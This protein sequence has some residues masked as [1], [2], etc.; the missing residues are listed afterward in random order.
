[1]PI[2][3]DFEAS[4]LSKTSYPIE[5]GWVDATGEGESLLIRPPV[6]W[7]DW[8]DS[9]EAIHG[10]TRA[11]LLEQGIEVGEVCRRLIALWEQG[12]VY[13]SA[14]SW[15]GAWLSRLLRAGGHPRH[16]LRLI[17]SDEAFGEAARQAGIPESAI[18]GRIAAARD[19]AAE[20][21]VAHRAQADA[22]REWSIWQS[23]VAVTPDR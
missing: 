16:L 8:D 22:R 14:P 12:P 2:F 6:D 13:A 7:T 11:V 20:N 21:G 1:M 15:D 23:L 18:A 10:I 4:S 19:A 17:D 9:A 3:L 5:V